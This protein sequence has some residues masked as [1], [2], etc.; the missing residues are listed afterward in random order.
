M[1]SLGAVI[2]A[3]TVYRERLEEEIRARVPD[4]RFVYVGEAGEVRGDPSDAEIFFNWGLTSDVVEPVIRA[5]PALRWFH[6]LSA[7]VDSLLFPALRDSGI[8]LTNARG[9]FAIPIAESVLAVM[10]YVAKNLRQNFADAARRHWQRRPRQ[11]LYGVTAG[12]LGLGAIGCEVARRLDAFGMRVIGLKRHPERAQDVQVEAL[13]GPGQLDDFLPQCDWVIVCAALTAASRALLG[14]REFAAM[15]DDAWLVNVARGEIAD[16]AA[17]LRALDEGRIGGACLDAF[18]QEPL[19]PESPFWDH[20]RVVVTP[21]NA[22]VS[23]RTEARSLALALENFDRY[24]RGETLR[25]VV[26]KQAGY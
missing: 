6:H 16:E 19:P 8:V 17:L 24:L 14:P 18:A 5:A 25:N 1:G 2:L 7:G 23:P 3:D 21:H 10:L 11:E 12:I 9:V 22:S 26:D 4:V 20:P 13:Y 15:K